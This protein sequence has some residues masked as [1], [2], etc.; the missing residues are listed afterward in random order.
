MA[1]PDW[2]ALAAAVLSRRDTASRGVPLSH[3][4]SVGQ[5]DTCRI[6]LI[7]QGLKVSH[8]VSHDVS[9][10]DTP[11]TVPETAEGSRPAPAASPSQAQYSVASLHCPTVPPPSSGTAG[12]LAEI[13]GKPPVSGVPLG[14]ETKP[15]VGQSLAEAILATWPEAWVVAERPA[16]ALGSEVRRWLGEGA[17]VEALGDGYQLTLPDGRSL[18]ITT[19]GCATLDDGLR[20]DLAE[21]AAIATE[22][23]ARPSSWASPDPPPQGAWCLACRGGR[24]WREREAPRG[25]RCASCCPPDH[26]PGAAVVTAP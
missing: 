10:R 15:A 14:C 20:G 2:A 12:H 9:R 13:G 26:L 11:G 3:P 24:F 4:Y 23:L 22:H 1:A 16:S 7:D 25:W 21:R 8:G 17:T 19:K 5:W 6:S 18:T